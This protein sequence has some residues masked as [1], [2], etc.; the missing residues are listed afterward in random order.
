MERRKKK[1]LIADDDPAVLDVLTMFLEELGYEVDSTEEGA[2][3][4]TFPS[5]MPDL[6]LLDIR[7]SGWNG[8]DL[9]R[10]L[11]NQEAT[12]QLPILLFSADREVETMARE[13]GADDFLDKPFDLAALLQ[14]IE[15][16]L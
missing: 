2:R 12:R 11:K 3:I 1:V 13:A 14:K 6:L 10:H 5:G 8:C 9:C 4:G 15:R 16:W 7:M